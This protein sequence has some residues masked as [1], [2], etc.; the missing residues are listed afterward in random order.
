[1]DGQGQQDAAFVATERGRTAGILSEFLKE[2]FDT[3]MRAIDNRIFAAF[4]KT[5]AIP[6]DVA[7]QAWLEKFAIWRLRASLLREQNAGAS[8]GRSL[9]PHMKQDFAATTPSAENGGYDDGR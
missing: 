4:N 2:Q 3:Q 1:M 7:I 6:A 9:E 5:G 8:A